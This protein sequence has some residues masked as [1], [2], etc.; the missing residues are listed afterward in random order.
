MRVHAGA[1]V[2]AEAVLGEGTTVWPVAQIR[3]G[4]TLG[5][6]CVI[7]RGAYVGSG[8]VMGDNCKLQ[9]FA[10]VYEPAML[11]DG[12]FVGPA[13]VFTNDLYPRSITPDGRLKRGADWE[14]VGVTVREGAS[15]GA[16]AVCVAPVTIG[17]WALIAAGS[18]VTKDVADFS[19]VAGTPARHLRWVGKS[20]LP[21]EPESES[22]WRCPQT[23]E[24]YAE[25]D[26]QLSEVATT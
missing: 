10:L 4:A 14:A 13:A 9:N 6:N 25:R 3:E 2:S 5:R 20:G 7:G 23:G 16:G 22:V 24:R 26:G 15:I 11:E 21:L 17:R 8:V 19:L 12:V 18:V 1:D